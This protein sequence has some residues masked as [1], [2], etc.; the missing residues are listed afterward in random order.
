M[1]AEAQSYSFIRRTEGSNSFERDL[2]SP[3]FKVTEV[4]LSSDRN[5]DKLTDRPKKKYSL[6]ELLSGGSNR[7]D[8]RRSQQ[9]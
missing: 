1:T 9:N 3:F 4:Q 7:P 8:S 2:I 5:K 6:Q